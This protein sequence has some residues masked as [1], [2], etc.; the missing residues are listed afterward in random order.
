MNPT[1]DLLLQIVW[2]HAVAI[3]GHCQHV[4]IQWPHD[5]QC[6]MTFIWGNSSMLMSKAGTQQSGHMQ[7]FLQKCNQWI[8]PTYCK[9]MAPAETT[10]QQSCYALQLSR[11]GL[12]W[13]PLVPG[14]AF[15]RLL[16]LNFCHR[17]AISITLLHQSRQACHF[18]SCNAMSS[19]CTICMNSMQWV[20]FVRGAATDPLLGI[21]KY[22]GF[23][24]QGGT[25]GLLISSIEHIA[26]IYHRVSTLLVYAPSQSC[27]LQMIP[28]LHGRQFMTCAYE[29]CRFFHGTCW[30]DLG[31]VSLCWIIEYR[32]IWTAR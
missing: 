16:H 7:E 23:Y 5:P 17:M 12:T 22:I 8:L 11:P 6:I 29:Q 14:L 24:S 31:T 32:S 13:V 25:L 30:K 9:Y 4:K 2:D 20:H 26:K 15:C 21:C 28:E 1:W 19:I 18:K 3:T 10:E 27:R